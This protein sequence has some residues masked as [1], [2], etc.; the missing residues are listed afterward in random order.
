[1]SIDHSGGGAAR[2]RR[3]APWLLL[4]LCLPPLG[5]LLTGRGVLLSHDDYTSD[6]LHS[7]LPYRAFLGRW[8]RQGE[9]PSWFPDVYSG[10]P[11][12]AQLESG[13][14]YPPNALLYTFLSPFAALDA[15][16]VLHVLLGSGGTYLLARVLGAKPLPAALAGIAFGLSGFNVAHLKHRNMHESAAWLPW[17]FLAVEHRLAGKG[18][19]F[20]VVLGLSVVSRWCIPG[21]VRWVMGL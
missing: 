2:Q 10:V 8:L 14:F 18:R 15:S 5:R 3:L 1:M 4:L 21:H 20:D 19:R 7:Q 13:A 9:F 11:L 16:I 17:I 12:A 6:L